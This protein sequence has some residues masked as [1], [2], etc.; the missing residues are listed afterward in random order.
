MTRISLS[1]LENLDIISSMTLSL[2]PKLAVLFVS[3]IVGTHLQSSPFAI[4]NAQAQATEGEVQSLENQEFGLEPDQVKPRKTQTKEQHSQKAPLED[5]QA[6][7]DPITIK[8]IDAE[9]FRVTLK[10]KST[11]GRV[12]LLEDSSEN[13]PNPGK[14]LLLKSNTADIAA[15]R[16]LKNYPGKFAVKIVLP[17]QKPEIGQEYRTLKKIG[18]KMIEMIR[19]REKRGADLDASKSDDDLAREI[20][21]DDNELDRGIPDPKTIKSTEEKKG[22][23]KKD[24][25]APKPLFDKNGEE[26]DEDEIDPSEADDS[27]SVSSEESQIIEPQRHIITLQYAS[28]RNIDKEANSTSYNAV[29]ARY[30]FNIFRRA[31][32]RSK[33]VQDAI[34]LELSLFRYTINGFV[35]STDSVTVVPLLGTIRYNVLLRENFTFFGYLGL[36]KNNV[37]IDTGTLSD[38]TAKLAKTAPI[39]G[40]GA[41][42]RIGPSW[43]VRID[44]G[45]DLFAIGAVLKF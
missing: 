7:A 24:E 1:Q 41:M 37:S 8:P 2:W 45:L 33:N 38:S 23:T 32:L 14:I 43:G 31:L 19:E 16:V 29:G 42:L 18:D 9:E 4:L 13:H 15:V 12:L 35:T 6:T 34:T 20:S 11:S 22:K 28:M 39:A 44:G 25:P 40:I 27:S 5:T 30:G 17:F 36:I 21:P 26:L 3:G 10:K